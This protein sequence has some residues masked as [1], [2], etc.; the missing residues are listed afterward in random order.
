MDNPENKKGITIKINGEE[1]PLVEDNGSDSV[2]VAKN[3]TSAAIEPE[4]E[5][6][7]WVFPK[8][9]GVFYQPPA[10]MKK[11]NS[12]ILAFGGKR[13]NPG[14]KSGTSLKL[15]FFA[16]LFAVIIGSSLGV[17][18]LKTITA[19]KEVA[20]VPVEPV[21]PSERVKGDKKTAAA[22]TI[23]PLTVYLVQGGMF[24]NEEAA[25]QTQEQV[26][27]KGVPTKILKQGENYY[28]FLG[29]ATSLDESK[30]LA[31]FLKSY[32][33]EVF[34]KELT[35]KPGSVASGHGAIMNKMITV[36]Q[37]LT[38]ASSEQL[39]NPTATT[40]L[41]PFQTELE[42]LKANVKDDAPAGLKA[43]YSDLSVAADLIKQY[44]STKET[45]QLL[46]AQQ[47]L[48]QFLNSYQI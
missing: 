23:Q 11:K 35:L 13:K 43:A 46:K 3:Q 4:D 29:S 12:T 26:T 47:K 32:D 48:L 16:I 8:D 18:V 37:N 21:I 7:E 36:Y 27:A 5:G 17:I 45:S 38:K 6:F 41:K 1:K 28:L 33:V 9:E 30:Q 15:P 20:A 34:W 40:D 22:S 24:S 14:N 39:L 31:I 10:S 2:K 19:D 44:Q 25:K 42:E